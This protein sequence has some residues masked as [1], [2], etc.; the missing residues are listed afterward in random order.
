MY[1]PSVS[2]PWLQRVVRACA[3]ALA[4]GTIVEVLLESHPA[5]QEI[6]GIAGAAVG[7]AVALLATLPLLAIERAPRVA[8]L[9][10]ASGFTATVMLGYSANIGALAIVAG[11][12][13]AAFQVGFRGALPAVAA[14]VAALVVAPIHLDGQLTTGALVNVGVI[15]LATLLGA[16]GRTQERYAGELEARTRE[17]EALIGVET[18]EAV[19]QER[20]RIARDVHDVVGHALAAIAL[21]ARVAGRRLARD[22][23]GAARS[24]AEVAEL[25][26]SA[27]A[28]TRD[29]VGPLRRPGDAAELRPQPSLDDLDELVRRLRDSGLAVELHRQLGGGTIPAV[30]QAAAFRIVQESLSNVVHHASRGT[31]TV[32]LRR[33]ASALRVEVHDD[34]PAGGPLGDGADATAGHGLLGMRERALGLGGS[35]EAGP[36]PDGGWRVRA[37]LPIAQA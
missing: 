23:A 31:A 16:A 25:A 4:A 7:I 9:L 11:P 24:L 15:L 13:L 10:T 6:D 8:P 1:R 35:L 37:T 21:H 30:V 29:A 34:G 20:L 14:S 33:D 18:R 22:P 3:V 36:G 32:E 2:R 12:G 5:A 27:L 17:L 28:E 26:T 19:A